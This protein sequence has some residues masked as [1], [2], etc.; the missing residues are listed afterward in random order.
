MQRARE[1]CNERAT[2][3]SGR[4]REQ[5]TGARR[6]CA[7]GRAYASNLSPASGLPP[8]D[9]RKCRMPSTAP[10]PRLQSWP[11]APTVQAPR[12]SRRSQRPQPHSSRQRMRMRLRRRGPAGALSG[13]QVGGLDAASSQRCSRGLQ[14]SRGDHPGPAVHAR[15][16]SCC[17]WLCC[18]P[19]LVSPPCLVAPT[20]PRSRGSGV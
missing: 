17:V 4:R 15:G 5:A 8:S 7:A 3:G 14:A 1:R 16:H 13:R 20:P 11:A 9:P 10:P 12:R 6:R 19:G 2:A 18:V